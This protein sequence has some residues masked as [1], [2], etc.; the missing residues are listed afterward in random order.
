MEIRFDT[1]AKVR[2]NYIENRFTVHLMQIH[3]EEKQ[4][5]SQ[6]SVFCQKPFT[7]DPKQDKL[8]NSLTFEAQKIF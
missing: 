2:K 7:V 8:K 4:H 5:D 1:P 3:S 6:R